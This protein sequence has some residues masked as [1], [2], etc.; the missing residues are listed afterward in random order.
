MS[1]TITPVRPLSLPK[2]G[3]PSAILAGLLGL[4]LLASPMW[5]PTPSYADYEAEASSNIT[6]YLLDTSWWESGDLQWFLAWA[7]GLSCV[8]A[9]LVGRRRPVL[10]T[11]LAV[12]PFV[13]IPLV[14]TFVWGWWLGLLMVTCLVLQDSWR[15]AAVPLVATTATAWLYALSGV[16]ASLPIGPVY[17][18]AYG[19]GEAL[20]AG[21]IYTVAIALVVTAALVVRLALASRRRDRAAAAAERRAIE[22]ESVA[23]ERARLAR[24]LHDVVAHHV[25]LV[26]VRAE[27]A[28]Y[29]YPGMNDDARGVL[30]EIADDARAALSE[31]RQV[32][33]VLQRTDG[34]ARAP[35][36]T[37]CD[38]ADL[39]AQAQAAGQDVTL[40]GECEGIPDAQGY[41]L[42]RAAQEALTNSRRHAPGVPTRMVIA[43]VADVA[44][45]RVTNPT[46]HARVIEP[47]RGLHGMR[48]RVE[49]LGGAVTVEV[50]DSTFVLVV[51]LPVADDG[52]LRASTPGPDAEGEA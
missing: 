50:E 29:T 30:G 27:S 49:A 13:T 2:S 21:L 34:S 14:G 28:P 20:Q 11:V 42:Y 18:G 36:P 25:S 3:V 32:L 24:D 9:V 52:R 17:A 16:P 26:A 22:V 44:G 4:F 38:I 7:A 45:L 23:V 40:S 10:A 5:L 41:V 51:T 8:A 43:N 48:E 37:A 33:T 19:G 46:S 47:G 15:R 35:Q 6:P 31:L 12:W 1:T 39:V